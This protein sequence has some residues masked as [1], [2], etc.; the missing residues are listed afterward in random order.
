MSGASR[1]LEPCVVVYQAPDLASPPPAL[2]ITPGERVR[3]RQQGFLRGAQVN[4][5][6]AVSDPGLPDCLEQGA[7]VMQECGIVPLDHQ[8]LS[9]EHCEVLDDPGKA[10]FPCSEL[11]ALTGAFVEADL[12][13]FS[14]Q[15]V[16]DGSLP[17]VTLVL[18]V[19]APLTPQ[20]QPLNVAPDERHVSRRQH[21]GHHQEATLLGFVDERVKRHRGS[22]AE[23]FR[24]RCADV[25]MWY[26]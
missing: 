2:C 7:A 8:P 14:G 22:V 11:V 24:K 19:N 9:T 5:L 13:R 18:E 17:A 16:E 23:M 25:R 4:V 20:V 10:G 1:Y 15:H 21:R 26:N 6:Q 3:Q 12:H